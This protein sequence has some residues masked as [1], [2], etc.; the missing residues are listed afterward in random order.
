MAPPH[1]NFVYEGFLRD[2]RAPTWAEFMRRFDLTRGE[3]HAAMLQLS[4]DHDAVLLRPQGAS[5]LILMS[6]PFS[7]IATPHEAHIEAAVVE[8]A[9][10]LLHIGDGGGDE[11]GG[12]GG[13]DA[14]IAVAAAA[15]PPPPPPHPAIITRYGN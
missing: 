1:R 5:D 12:G 8:Q 10:R 13:S 3:A 7:N 14:A 6:H 15:A 4:A 2:G 11:G 9:V